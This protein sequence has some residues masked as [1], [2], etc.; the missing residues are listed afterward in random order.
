MYFDVKY[1]LENNSDLSKAY[2]NTY[3]V[4]LNHFVSIGMK[5]ERNSSSDFKVSIYKNNYEDL[6]KAFGNDILSYYEHYILYGKNEGR[7]AK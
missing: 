7:K 5:E 2:G 6:R 4:A 1:Y 3:S